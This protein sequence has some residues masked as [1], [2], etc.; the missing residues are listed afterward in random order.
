[1]NSIC[2]WALQ[3]LGGIC[4]P[5]K[6]FLRSEIAPNHPNNQWLIFFLVTRVHSCCLEPAKTSLPWLR[7]NE[8]F[9]AQREGNWSVRQRSLTHRE[10]LPQR[11][12]VI[13]VLRGRDPAGQAVTFNKYSQ[14][15]WPCSL[16]THA[17]IPRVREQKGVTMN[18]TCSLY[19]PAPHT[20]LAVCQPHPG[21]WFLS[22]V[23]F[24]SYCWNLPNT[25]VLNRGQ[26]CSPGDIWQ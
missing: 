15:A 7:W 22:S 2:Y 8:V 21:H 18:M 6:P 20:W 16:S 24:C 12:A 17:W 5:N 26:F 10:S 14:S 23:T 4:L 9:P 1:M 3:R 19:L 25:V 13:L 11:A